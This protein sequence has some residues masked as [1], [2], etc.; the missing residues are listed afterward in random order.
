[1]R[2]EWDEQWDIFN[3]LGGTNPGLYRGR[4]PGRFVAYQYRSLITPPFNEVNGYLTYFSPL[5]RA[6]TIVISPPLFSLDPSTGS[7]CVR[8]S[9]GFTQHILW[10]ELISP[11]IGRAH[12]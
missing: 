2:R 10:R 4:I 5:V 12:V 9:D 6:G 3:G 8:V 11:Q 7:R 1:M